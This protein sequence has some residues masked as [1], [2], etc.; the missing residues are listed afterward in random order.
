MCSEGGSPEFVIIDGEDFIPVPRAAIAPPDLN[1]GQMHKWESKGHTPLYYS[2]AMHT[3]VFLR[4]T[5]DWFASWREE[6][7]AD[8]ADEDPRPGS[9][10]A[11]WHQ[12]GALE[13]EALVETDPLLAAHLLRPQAFEL[14]Q[15]LGAQGRSPVRYC[16]VSVED[17]L[18]TPTVVR[19]DGVAFRVG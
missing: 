5:A 16:M 8:L 7:L 19:M 4:L 10:E 18:I 9:A 1:F 2:C 15:L 13:L 11:Y 3:P 14:C 17:L 12:L 6:M